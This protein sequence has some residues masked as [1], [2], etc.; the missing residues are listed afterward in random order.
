[1]RCKDDYESLKGTEL[2]VAFSLL[3]DKIPE[4]AKKKKVTKKS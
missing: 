1:M 3:D 4:Y 2:E